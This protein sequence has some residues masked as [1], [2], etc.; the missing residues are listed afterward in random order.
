M[1]PSKIV[2]ALALASQTPL[3]ALAE[4]RVDYTG[5]QVLRINPKEDGDVPFLRD[6][7]KSR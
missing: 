7:A 6:L 2:L 4:P 3:S 1:A 5:Y